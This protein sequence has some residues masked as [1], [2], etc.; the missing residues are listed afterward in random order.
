[1]AYAR[2]YDSVNGRPTQKAESLLAD[3]RAKGGKH[4]V[5][6][7]SADLASVE[8]EYEGQKSIFSLSW[9][10]AKTASFVKDRDGKYKPTWN[11]PF[12]RT[13]MLWA[14][15]ISDGV[16]TLA[17]EIA[18]G[19]TVTEEAEDIDP[20]QVQPVKSIITISEK[21]I[22]PE[23]TVKTL[24][25]ALAAATHSAPKKAVSEQK[26]Q[27]VTDPISEPAPAPIKTEP[28]PKVELAI[29][30]TTNELT[31][32]SKLAVMAAIGEQNFERAIEVLIARGQ[33]PEGSVGIEKLD[34]AW[35]R[36]IVDFREKFI[37]FI[38]GV[39]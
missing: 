14:R 8:L 38:G 18:T 30:P 34:L 17:P 39:L 12:L 16:H 5:I 23:P 32:A 2:K 10:E 11:H 33:L 36:R 6:S 3:F 26:I 37:K 4:R 27:P 20:S 35:A 9:E 1:L 28:P 19:V 13:K 29:D 15:V 24:P 31:P 21:P 22:Q 7:R 25:P